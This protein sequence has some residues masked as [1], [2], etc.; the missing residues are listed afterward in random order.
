MIEA[1][2]YR[3]ELTEYEKEKITDMING[4][5]ESELNIVAK[6]VNERLSKANGN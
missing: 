4:L 2:P 6:V 5:S 1:R 3:E